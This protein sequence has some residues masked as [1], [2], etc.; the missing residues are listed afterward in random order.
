[1]G[2]NNESKL[3][4]AS[5]RQRGFLCEYEMHSREI[6]HCRSQL[7]QKSLESADVHA[8]L[9]ASKKKLAANELVLQERQRELDNVKN[10]ILEADRVYA[11][12]CA[13]RANSCKWCQCAGNL[14]QTVQDLVVDANMAGGSRSSKRMRQSLQADICSLQEELAL[15]K[16]YH[17]IFS[18][19]EY[20]ATLWYVNELVLRVCRRS[21][22]VCE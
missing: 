15:N 16:K 10:Q 19:V 21:F 22:V 20:A 1:M 7:S 12:L 18:D 11:S 3:Q 6:K 4:H 2:S 9:D 14:L 13:H 5:Q 17:R 8:L